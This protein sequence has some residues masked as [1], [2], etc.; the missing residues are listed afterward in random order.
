MPAINATLEP[1]SHVTT[2]CGGATQ[3]QITV[4]TEQTDGPPVVRQYWLLASHS[5]AL[6]WNTEIDA[7]DM[8]STKEHQVSLSES[9]SYQLVTT[10][11]CDSSG[12]RY[13]RLIILAPVCEAGSPSLE[14]I[15]FFTYSWLGIQAAAAGMQEAGETIV[16]SGMFFPFLGRS[17]VASAS[18]RS[19][20]R[21]PPPVN[22][23]SAAKR[24]SA[25]ENGRRGIMLIVNPL[26]IGAMLLDRFRQHLH[27]ASGCI[28]QA[29]GLSCAMSRIFMSESTGAAVYLFTDDH[30]PPHVHARHRDDGWIARVQFSFVNND[31][32]LMSIAPAKH[33]PL[34]RVVDKLLDDVGD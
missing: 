33:V 20:I 24:Q 23:M 13:P 30:C 5:Y 12:W 15:S 8:A 10:V 21:K 19:G 32:A 25:Q 4:S 7:W 27:G 29:D 16:G 22:L 26:D 11:L 3:F 2:T 14:S 1:D 31:V 9:S 18:N 6:F 34:Q 28:T 17:D